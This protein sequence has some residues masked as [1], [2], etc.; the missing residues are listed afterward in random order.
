MMQTMPD[1][2]CELPYHQ[3]RNCLSAGITGIMSAL[4]H[5]NLKMSE[6]SHNFYEQSLAPLLLNSF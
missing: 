5:L 2:Q 1:R 3:H 6:F 4:Y